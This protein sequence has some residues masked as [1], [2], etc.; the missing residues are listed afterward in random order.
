L[1]GEPK[2]IDQREGREDSEK[3]RIDLRREGGWV[4][5]ERTN[6]E[7]LNGTDVESSGERGV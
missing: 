2:G 3:E 5:V 1:Q 6:E 4:R 7:M